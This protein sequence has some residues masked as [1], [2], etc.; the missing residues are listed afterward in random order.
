[1]SYI[2]Q[3]LKKAQTERDDR[4]GKY[5]GILLSSRS[6][7]S[8]LFRRWALIAAAVLGILF[9]AFIAYS[10]LDLTGP[11]ATTANPTKPTEAASAPKKVPDKSANAE[12]LYQGGRTHHRKGRLD[13]AKILYEKAL[14]VDPGCVAALNNL[15]VILMAEN[16]YPAARSR[17]EKAIRLRPGYVDPCYNLACLFALIDQPEQGLRYL[18]RAV[19]LHPQVKAWALEDADLEKLRRQPGFAEIVD[20]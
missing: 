18:K 7:K 16:N 17:F 3:A 13:Q 1:V 14:R 12:A 4:Y 20:R 19:S 9:L 11:R 5:E 2:H 15:G 8:A 6:K 10:W